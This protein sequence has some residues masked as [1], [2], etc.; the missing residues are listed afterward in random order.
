[1]RSAAAAATACRFISFLSK[2]YN[3]GGQQKTTDLNCRRLLAWWSPAQ[4]PHFQLSQLSIVL[5]KGAVGFARSTPKGNFLTSPPKLSIPALHAPGHY[6]M[7]VSVV[8]SAKRL[9]NP[10]YHWGIPL[11]LQ[12]S[13]MMTSEEDL[14]CDYCLGS[15]SEMTDPR[16]LDCSHVYCLPCLEEDLA[17]GQ[18]GF[19]RCSICR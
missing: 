5:I 12:D 15:T 1:M 13:R 16:Q 10:R 14:R 17:Q 2:D 6:F 11:S 4:Q 9:P 7:S 8:L 3:D 19:F 18:P